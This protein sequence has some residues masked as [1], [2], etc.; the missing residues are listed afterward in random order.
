[1]YWCI[2]LS[3]DHW[4]N[5]ILT[6]LDLLAMVPRYI[7]LWSPVMLLLIVTNG[8]KRPATWSFW[9]G[10]SIPEILAVI[11]L[12]WFWFLV[13]CHARQ[14]FGLLFFYLPN[15]HAYC[16][17]DDDLF[18]DFDLRNCHAYNRARLRF[19]QFDLLDCHAYDQL[20]FFTYFDLLDCHA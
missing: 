15:C 13:D 20:C 2:F 11:F 17:T 5:G 19:P 12:F 8:N 10:R 9:C 14:W 18:S 1:M 16:T 4:I 6:F 3:M 7:T